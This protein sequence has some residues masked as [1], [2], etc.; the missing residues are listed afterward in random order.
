[1]DAFTYHNLFETKGIEYLVIILFLVLLIPF[2]WFLNR[3]VKIGQKIREL[4]G[5]ISAS[6]LKIPQ[7]IYHS[8]NHTW[9][10]LLKNGLAEV[11]A[12]DLL[13]HL[14]GEIRVTVTTNPGDQIERGKEMAVIEH[15]GQKLRLFSP[16]SGAVSEINPVF[17]SGSGIISSDPYG[18]GWI[19]KINPADWKRDTQ[20]Y[21]L[22]GSAA[23]WTERELQKFKEFLAEKLPVYDPAQSG[24]ILQDGGELRDQVLTGLPPG[25]W[26]EFQKEFLNPK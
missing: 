6:V 4:G 21:F 17:A 19:L 22:A 9:A 25:I 16:L 7:G 23:S 26:D 5:F 24:I 14:T 20:G 15:G 1:M 18:E 10:H 11:G 8:P 2:S 12:D 13:L 3:K